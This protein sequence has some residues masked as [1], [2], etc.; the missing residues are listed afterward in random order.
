MSVTPVQDKD[1]TQLVCLDLLA[2]LHIYSKTMT[3]FTTKNSI[4]EVLLWKLL[5]TI[6]ALMF[7]YPALG[8]NTT[9]FMV[10]IINKKLHTINLV[11][12]DS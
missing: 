5:I 9:N 10:L 8:L 7:L 12:W 1:A 6:H 4:D 11:F 3:N 2:S